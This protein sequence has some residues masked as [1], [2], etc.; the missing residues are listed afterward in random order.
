MRIEPSKK[1]VTSAATA[2]FPIVGMSAGMDARQMPVPAMVKAIACPTGSAFA[3]ING[4]FINGA[5]MRTSCPEQRNSGRLIAVAV[6]N[7]PKSEERYVLTSAAG[8]YFA[9]AAPMRIPTTM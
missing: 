6:I 5:S 9:I 1:A 7:P 8:A 2:L 3:P 4:V